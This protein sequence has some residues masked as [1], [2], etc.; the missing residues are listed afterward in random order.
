MEFQKSPCTHLTL[1]SVS[2]N[3]VMDT[4]VC[5]FTFCFPYSFVSD[6]INLHRNSQYRK[7]SRKL[8]LQFLGEVSA[9]LARDRL[10]A[11]RSEG[12]EGQLCEVLFVCSII[13]SVVYTATRRLTAS[14]SAGFVDCGYGEKYHPKQ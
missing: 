11:G 1:V 13:C 8:T 5:I 14:G 12:A 10:S 3:V 4:F 2:M 6:V 9:C 7:R